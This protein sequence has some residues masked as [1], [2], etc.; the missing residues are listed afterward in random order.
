M[1]QQQNRP[2]QDAST[3]CDEVTE[4]MDAINGVSHE[5]LSWQRRNHDGLEEL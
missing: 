5:A 4:Y 3:G 2:N 1:L